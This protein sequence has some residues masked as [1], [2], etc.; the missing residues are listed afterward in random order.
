[1]VLNFKAS[2]KA[3]A[4]AV[5]IELPRIS[6][7]LKIFLIFKLSPKAHEEASPSNP[8]NLIIKE[9]KPF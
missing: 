1:M 6:S 7:Y 4:A 8:I 5:P 9:I 2:P 3:I